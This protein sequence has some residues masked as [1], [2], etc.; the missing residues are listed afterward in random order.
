MLYVCATVVLCVSAARAESIT[1]VMPVSP[2][3]A[4]DRLVPGLAVTYFFG[5]FDHVSELERKTGGD[6]G[7]PVLVLDTPEGKAEVLTSGKKSNIGAKLRGLIEFPEPGTYTLRLRSNDGV[8]L[9][10]GGK[11][12]L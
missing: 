4:S 8:R 2:Q 10:I 7:Q 11:R 3:P 1:G 12:A 5:M 6:P 9:H